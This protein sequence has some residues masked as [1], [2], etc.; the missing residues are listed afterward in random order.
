MSNQQ[1]PPYNTMIAAPT[2]SHADNVPFHANGRRAINHT[3]GGSSSDINHDNIAFD[4]IY[5]ILTNH[6]QSNPA[7]ALSF[8][9]N[10]PT[11]LKIIDVLSLNGIERLIDERWECML[12]RVREWKE[13]G[14]ADN[15]ANGT[16]GG[17]DSHVAAL[18]TQ[19]NNNRY[20][21]QAELATWMNNW[22]EWYKEYEGE[23]LQK[24]SKEQSAAGSSNNNNST[25]TTAIDTRNPLTKER[26]ESLKD[27]GL[28]MSKWDRRYLE[29][30]EFKRVNGHCDVGIEVAG[31][32]SFAL[33]VVVVVVCYGDDDDVLSICIC[34]VDAI[35]PL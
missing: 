19:D 24:N 16:G 22:K 29:L 10:H 7:T 30:K 3:G 35:A 18:T 31:V 8:P 5:A 9:P 6:L 12:A 4:E 27:V 1:I 33:V 23:M 34:L 2:A 28:T 21:Q 20:D 13:H 32:S 26:Y 15:S 11:L 14:G 25:T 17:D